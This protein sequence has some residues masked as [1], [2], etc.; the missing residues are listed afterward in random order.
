MHTTSEKGKVVRIA[1]AQPEE[2]MQEEGSLSCAVQRKRCLDAVT[3]TKEFLYNAPQKID[4]ER[5]VYLLEAYR[6]YSNEPVI[7][8]RA[9]LFEL[10]L[11][12]K[13][14]YIDD[15]P[16]VGTVTGRPAGVYVF[17]EWDADWIIK[18]M[19][20][21]MMSH[22]GKVDITDEEKKLML[23]AARLFSIAAPTPS[24]AQFQAAALS[25]P[26]TAQGRPVHRR[27]PPSPWARATWTSSPRQGGLGPH[28]GK[29]RVAH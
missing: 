24:H 25:S 20:Q 23:E 27:H 22:L 4:T 14:L 11:H 19:N 18:D 17:P 26:R 7:V 29:S 10:L 28:R 16:I 8:L 13:R 6:E 12:K 21:A 15:N 3:K 9:K 5:L 2:C 1:T